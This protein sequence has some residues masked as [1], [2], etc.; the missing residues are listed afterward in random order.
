MNDQTR[1]ERQYSLGSH[2]EELARLD[3]Q[4]A[5]IERPTRQ[6]LQAAGLTPG[7]QVLDLGTGL[8]HVAMM[9]GEFV[10]ATGRVVGIDQAGEVITIARQRA[11][12]AGV[13][14]VTFEEG[15]VNTW[16]ADQSFD[17]I[18]A[19]LLLFH[20]ADPVAVVRHHT[21]NLR[22]ASV[23]VAIDFDIGTARS[24]PPVPIVSEATRWIQEAFQAAGAWPRIG[25]RLG[26][27]LESAGLRDVTTFGIQTYIPSHNVA[28]SGLIAGVVRS[29]AALILKHGIAT[30]EQ[31]DIATLEQRIGEQVREADAVIL[32]PTVA[33]AWGHTPAAP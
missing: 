30:A 13:T 11:K 32:P 12:D 8:G 28:G 31:L 18:T 22:P 7:M 29:L 21:N 16:R 26:T 10:T 24:E 5:L 14:H 9:S 1:L 27:I 25:A 33:G 19:R 4:A 15:D 17:A 3:R 23:F 6:L 2:S 20:V